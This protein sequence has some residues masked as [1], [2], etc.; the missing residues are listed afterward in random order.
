MNYLNLSL[1]Y[2]I[3]YFEG[4]SRKVING[5]AN[6]CSNIISDR[7]S[8]STQIRNPLFHEN[9]RRHKQT[10]PQFLHL[11]LATSTES[12]LTIKPSARHN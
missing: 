3:Q 7:F 10:P 11:D 8:F 1:S 2:I 12:C 9:R 4:K 6:I 5:K